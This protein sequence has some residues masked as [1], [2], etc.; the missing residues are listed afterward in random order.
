MQATDPE[1][2]I[3]ALDDQF[4]LAGQPKAT[5]KVLHPGA[6]VTF[7]S[8]KGRL[9]FHTDAF[10]WLH[11]NLHAIAAGLE[12]LRAIERYGI[13]SS[14]EQFAG[15]AQL[16]AGGPDPERGARLVERAGGVNAA[17]KKHHPD[18]GGD[19]RDIADVLAY[20]ER[21]GAGA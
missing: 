7:E 10:P 12:A 11:D 3:V 6:I 8:A 16:T 17:L 4:T 9:T 14:G 19:P 21:V 13:A 20:R 18:V 15:F 5:L 1:I 2:A